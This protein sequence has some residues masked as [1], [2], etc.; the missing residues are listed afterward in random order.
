MS[1]KRQ[2][3][4]YDCSHEWGVAYGTEQSGREMQ[5]PKCSSSNIHRADIGLPGRGRGPSPAGRGRG[6]PGRGQE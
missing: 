3:R 6:G 2:F 1:D 4:C 5:C